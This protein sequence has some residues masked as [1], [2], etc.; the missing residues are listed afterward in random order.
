MRAIARFAVVLICISP[1]WLLSQSTDASADKLQQLQKQLDEMKQQVATLQAQINA[2]SGGGSAASETPSAGSAAAAQNTKGQ[3]EASTE[4]TQGQKRVVVGATATYQTYSQDPLAAPR[5]DNAPLDPRYPGY[6]RLPGTQT[7]LR[8]GGYF[9]TDFIRDIR[10]AGDPER[11]IPSSI[12]VPTAVALTN[13]TVSVRPTRLNLDFLVPT[14]SLGKVRFFVEG[15]LFGSSSTTPRMRHAYAQAKNF[16]IGQTFSN[17]MD[18][19]SGPD[20]LEF[21]GPNGQVSIRNPQLRYTIPIAE[22]TSLSFS[23]EKASSDVAFKTPEFSASTNNPTPDI[24]AKF[25]HDME[26]GHIQISG[27]FRD[28][29]ASLP[30]GVNDSTL[31]WGVNLTGLQKTGEKDNF[32]YQVAY[33]PGIERYI[34]DTSGLGIDAAPKSPTELSA[35]NVVGAYGA[36]QHFWAPKVR[37]SLIYGFVQVENE[38]LQPASAFHQSNYS[39]ANLIWNVAGSLN[40]GAEFLYGWVVKKDGSSGNAPRLMVSAKYN[41]V[42]DDSAKKK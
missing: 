39:A 4:L 17:F 3:S 29:A 15:D 40:V 7:F 12:P 28:V 42:R 38:G 20:Q 41:F 19:D 22:K 18:P 13:S 21:Q 23:V 32:V 33:G 37:S 10:Q 14:E 2:A 24:T 36:F 34:N 5:V 30:N 35:L 16:L 1:S 8:I 9:K 25:R 11:F 6:F 27:I 26:S 31:G